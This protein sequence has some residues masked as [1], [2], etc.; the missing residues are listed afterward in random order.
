MNAIFAERPD[1]G[2]EYFHVVEGSSASTDSDGIVC[3]LGRD[4][5]VQPDSLGAYCLCK[6][7]PRVDDLILIAG[8][9]A[10]ADKAARRRV[11]RSWERK[12][13]VSVPVLEPDFW[14]QRRISSA[15]SRVLFLLTGDEWL[16]TFVPRRAPLAHAKQAVLPFGDAPALVMPFSDGLDSLAVARLTAA[17]KPNSGLILVTTGRLADP[18]ADWR[19]RHFRGGYH[20]VSIPFSMPRG[21]DSPQLREPS[22]RSRAFLFGVMAGAAAALL[23][24]D[25]VI[26]SESGQGSLGPSLTP[27]G[28]ESPDLRMHPAYTRQLSELLGLVFDRTIHFE[29]PR[30]WFTKGETLATLNKANLADDWVRTRSCSR[31]ARHA[32]L[33]RQRAQCGVCANCLL[34]RQSLMA[35]GLD[36][37][38]EQYIWSRLSG[39]SLAEA[40]AEG[41]R[42]TRRNDQQHAVCGVLAMAELASLDRKGMSHS[43][44]DWA[45]ADLADA[46]DEPLNDVRLRLARLLAVHR[47]EWDDFVAAQGSDS[48]LARFAELVSP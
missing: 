7:P 45:T 38:Q 14:S 6:L 8:V 20:R 29:H 13:H 47:A 30:L 22:Y 11:T 18:D 15:L 10:Y 26:V 48:F 21:K 46:L 31:D 32:T 24:A 17:T 9:T 5:V 40:S 33:N 28:N 35:A 36:T 16:F 34:R 41:A 3:V 4:L 23:G 12:L 1:I 43:T 39:R 2:T 27:V 19:V 37:S 42:P 25:R 44:L